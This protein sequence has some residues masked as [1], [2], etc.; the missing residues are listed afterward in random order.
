MN[1]KKRKKIIMKMMK[2]REREREM[3]ELIKLS[4]HLSITIGI[5]ENWKSL[6]V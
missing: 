5:I 6:K 4:F 1:E 2:G 3:D